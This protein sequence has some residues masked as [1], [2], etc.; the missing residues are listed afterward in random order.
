M[1]PVDTA[2]F[3]IR[4][5][6]YNISRMYN[7]K[8]NKYGGTMA[9][10]YTLLNIDKDGT[11]STKLGPKMGMEPRSLTRMIKSLETK[12]WI[13]KRIDKNDKRMVNIYLTK[14][15]ITMRNRTRNSV[16]KFNKTIQ[17][18]IN[19]SELKTCFKVLNEINTL[20]DNKEIFKL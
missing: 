6:W 11:P 13:E 2:D 20:I 9:I 18:K 5:S 16:I 15:G 19:Q 3:H 14:T 12:G 4:W 7:T 10:G 17:E 1:K 8:A